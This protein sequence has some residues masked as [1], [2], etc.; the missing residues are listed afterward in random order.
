MGGFVAILPAFGKPAEVALLAALF[1]TDGLA[2][3]GAGGAHEA[4]AGTRLF[5]V[6]EVAVFQY[7]ADGVGNGEYQAAVL[8]NGVFSADAFELIDDLLGLYAATQ[9]QRDQPADGFCFSGGGTARFTNGSEDFK[10]F[11]VEL[12]DGHIEAP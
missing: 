12:R 5:L 6:F 8:K 9:G 1:K 2:A 10:G 4:V 7:V 11:S 3:L